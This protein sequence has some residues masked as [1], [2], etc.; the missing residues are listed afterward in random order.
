MQSWLLIILFWLVRNPVLAT[1]AGCVLC[2][3]KTSGLCGRVSTI[4]WESVYDAK[5]G[6]GTPYLWYGYYKLPL[7]Q[8][9]GS[10]R[11]AYVTSHRYQELRNNL[12]GRGLGR[13]ESTRSQIA[14]FAAGDILEPMQLLIA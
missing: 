14:W 11:R 10:E 13:A 1:L 5:Q 9:P 3:L 2:V 12:P 6:R 8:T 4:G 7:L